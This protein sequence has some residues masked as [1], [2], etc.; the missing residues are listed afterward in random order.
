M[1]IAAI[2]YRSLKDLLADVPITEEDPPTAKIIKRLNHVMRDGELS[3]GEFLDICHWKSPRSLR[4]CERN[5]ARLIEK[6]SCQVFATNDESARLHLLTGLQGVSVPTAS[7][8]LTLTDPENYG[9]IDIRV[10]Q[11]LHKLQSVTRNPRGQGFTFRQWDLY[12]N[13]LR[14]H[15]KRLNVAVRLVELTL[16]Q[17]HREHQAGPMY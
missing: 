9:V 8:I 7:A 14:D 16:F 2:K 5:S 6:T 10:W 4:L 15:A 11:L 17:F 3:R 13:I 12:L 1:A